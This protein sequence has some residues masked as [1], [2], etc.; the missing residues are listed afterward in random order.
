MLL[1]I[2]LSSG[3]KHALRCNILELLSINRHQQ[4]LSNEHFDA[5]GI[6]AHLIECSACSSSSCCDANDILMCDGPCQRAFHQDCLEPKLET[7]DI[8]EGDN[9]WWCHQCDALLDCM[10]MISERLE[11]K[12]FWENKNVSYDSIRCSF[13]SDISVSRGRHEQAVPNY[14][15]SDM[16]NVAV[17]RKVKA[18]ALRIDVQGVIRSYDPK[19]FLY[20]VVYQD[21]VEQELTMQDIELTLRRADIGMYH[22]GDGSSSSSSSSSGTILDMEFDEDNDEDFD[23][24]E[25]QKLKAQMDDSEDSGDSGDSGDS[26]DSDDSDDESDSDSD[27]SDSDDKDSDEDS[28]DEDSE[29]NDSKDT[30]DETAEAEEELTLLWLFTRWTRLVP[31]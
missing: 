26:D 19:T 2:L 4:P 23:E 21:G 24:E 27:D 18:N 20:L 12:L 6:D 25:I 3:G 29:D 15:P 9:D 31:P 5:D 14:V 11:I 10:D 30:K 28:E 13:L 1:S 8:P 17:C 16:I 22:V 7:K